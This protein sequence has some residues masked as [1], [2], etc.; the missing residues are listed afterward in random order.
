MLLFRLRKYIKHLRQCFIGYPN[1]SHFVKNDLVCV[2][3]S[4]LLTVFGYRDEILSAMSLVFDHMTI[5]NTVKHQNATL[6]NHYFTFSRTISLSYEHQ[7]LRFLDLYFR[8]FT[9]AISLFQ[10]W[11]RIGVNDVIVSKIPH[12]LKL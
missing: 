3:F 10:S 2:V 6:D 12:G 9:A 11:L 5:S 8:E 1:T 4:I 7:N